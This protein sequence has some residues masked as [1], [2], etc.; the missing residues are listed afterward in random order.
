MRQSTGAGWVRFE[1]PIAASCLALAAI[2]TIWNVVA[3]TA[4]RRQIGHEGRVVLA[5]ERLLSATRD[6]ETG[7]RGYA[8][9]GQDKYL[10]PYRSSLASL[11][12]IEASAR[13]AW[14]AS[15]REA[16]RLTPVF[17]MIED[18]RMLAARLVA[19]RTLHSGRSFAQP[20]RNSLQ[21][22]R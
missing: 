11:A 4:D 18:K 17:D 5:L 1:V 3:S 8:L 9:A 19:T 15:G 22:F 6:I 21:G 2:L 16:D 7:S 12:G 20:Q 14:T 13:D 10:D